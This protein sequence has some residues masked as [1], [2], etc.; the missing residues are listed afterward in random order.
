MTARPFRD[1]RAGRLSLSELRRA[2]LVTP[3]AGVEL[4][5]Y[6]S[7]TMG[8]DAL[9]PERLILAVESWQPRGRRLIPRDPRTLRPDQLRALRGHHAR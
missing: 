1:Y 2:V 4:V 6:D 7:D 5:P 3:G 9:D 8:T